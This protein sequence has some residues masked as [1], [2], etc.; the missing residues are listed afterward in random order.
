[1]DNKLKAEA[2]DKRSVIAKFT[3]EISGK[4]EKIK[5][6]EG[7]LSAK[8]SEIDTLKI[9]LRERHE[10]VNTLVPE[11][12]R[13]QTLNAEMKSVND[14]RVKEF[15]IL[16]T[17][18]ERLKSEFEKGN[19]EHLATVNQLT[20]KLESEQSRHEVFIKNLEQNA[21][22]KAEEISNLQSNLSD[23]TKKISD[24]EKKL[25]SLGKMSSDLASLEEYRVN[26]EISIAE[27]KRTIQALQ[28]DLAKG[29]A[30][31]AQKNARIKELERLQESMF[32]KD[33]EIQR[34]KKVC[35][36]SMLNSSRYY[37]LIHL[38]RCFIQQ[39]IW[40]LVGKKLV[41]SNQSLMCHILH[42]RKWLKIFPNSNL[43]DT[44]LKLASRKQQMICLF[45]RE[46]LQE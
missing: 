44:V 24:L 36:S 5:R 3:R 46:R 6:L 2:Q 43:S 19:K 27:S 8:D 29:K 13:L 45:H 12:A 32:G 23:K 22:A 31:D 9:G 39:R 1:M 20:T 40:L 26:T 7:N 15:S 42:K 21:K 10:D 37:F 41:G 14:A 11:V 33:G 35:T 16:K 25:G 30:E 34:L 18:A 4:D 17:E 28:N 38:Q